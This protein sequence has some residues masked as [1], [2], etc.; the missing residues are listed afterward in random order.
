MMAESGH[1]WR[2]PAL[3]GAEADYPDVD[4]KHG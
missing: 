3:E 4:G 1:A 2:I